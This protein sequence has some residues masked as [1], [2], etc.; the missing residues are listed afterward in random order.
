MSEV[1]ETVK[2]TPA[3]KRALIWLSKQ[4]HPVGAI[5]NAAGL[6]NVKW[7]VKNGFV[8]EVGRE[9]GMFGFTLF[10]IN[11]AGRAALTDGGE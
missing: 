2:L 8:S 10:Q 6:H 3:K 4:Q 11:D 9:R 1:A 7:L 5:P